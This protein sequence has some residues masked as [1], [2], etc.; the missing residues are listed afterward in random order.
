MRDQL[1]L[2]LPSKTL[3]A[4]QQQC[5]AQQHV[6]A[7]SCRSRSSSRHVIVEMPSCLSAREMPTKGGEHRRVHSRAHGRAST[8]TTKQNCSVP[9]RMTFTVASGPYDKCTDYNLRGDHKDDTARALDAHS[10]DLEKNIQ[11]TSELQEIEEKCSEHTLSEIELYHELDQA[12]ILR[13]MRVME[14]ALAEERQRN[15]DNHARFS[16]KMEAQREAH[17]RDIQEL[18]NMVKNVLAENKRLSKMVAS[19]EEKSLSSASTSR[20]SGTP[21]STSSSDHSSSSRGA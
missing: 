20:G 17:S 16:A 11:A 21:C 7:S 9:V 19:W 15:A 1:D 5:A 6:G 14:V 12:T 4:Y 3:E 13:E 2:A 8:P 18:E 10:Q